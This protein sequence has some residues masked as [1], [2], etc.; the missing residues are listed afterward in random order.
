EGGIGTVRAAVRRDRRDQRRSA[1]RA[2]DGE[3]GS[4]R[5]GL[6][7]RHRAVEARRVERAPDGDAVRAVPQRRALMRYLSNTGPEQRAMLDTIGA[8]TIYEYQTMM[9]ELTGMDVANASIYDGGSSLA[10][11]VLMAANVTGRTE[12]VLAAGVNPLYRHVT[13]TYCQ[14]PGFKLRTAPAPDGVVDL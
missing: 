4:L 5:Q 11:A 1:E 14:G 8:R 12:I 6:D 9:A 13:V 3:S 2:A 7:D 10:E